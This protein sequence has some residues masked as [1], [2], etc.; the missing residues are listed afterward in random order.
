MPFSLS[1]RTKKNRRS[2]RFWKWLCY[3]LKVAVAVV[4]HPSNAAPYQ[5]GA[6]VA[7]APNQIAVKRVVVL[8]IVVLSHVVAILG[9]QLVHLAPLAAV[10]NAPALALAQA[11]R[12]LDY[13]GNRKV[14]ED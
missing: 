5:S 11:V 8:E 2:C 13:D 10:A 4:F 9:V 14:P 7:L 6:V 1:S 12:S 3:L